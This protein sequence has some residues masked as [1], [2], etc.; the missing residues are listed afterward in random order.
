MHENFPNTFIDWVALLGGIFTIVQFVIIIIQIY[1][2]MEDKKN[3]GEKLSTILRHG[4]AVKAQA[5]S[6]RNAG[7][8][9]K[10]ALLSSIETSANSIRIEIEEFRRHHWKQEPPSSS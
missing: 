5:S 2:S 7:A 3:I 9:D 6:C 8:A 10:D 1:R 4:D